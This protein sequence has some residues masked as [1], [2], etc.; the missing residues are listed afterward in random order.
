MRKV[1][2]RYVHTEVSVS[3]TKME[4]S[5]IVEIIILDIFFLRVTF[6]GT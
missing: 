2:N 6:G 5:E 1:E 4:K 3:S